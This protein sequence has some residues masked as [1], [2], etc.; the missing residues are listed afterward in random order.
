MT[1]RFFKM[2]KPVW[3]VIP[4]LMALLIT[5]LSVVRSDT[6][7]TESC[8]IADP[9]NLDFLVNAQGVPAIIL[10]TDFAADV[11]DVG[12]LAILNAMADSGEAD[13][14][15]VM[16]N[17]GDY[18]ALRAVDTINTYYGQPD[19]P[20][21]ATWA[22]AVSVTSKYTLALAVDFPNDLGVTPNAV[23]LYRQILAEQPDESVT[24]VSI[25]FLTNLH[26]LLASEPD[27]YSTLGGSALVAAKVR[28]LVVM[29]G[30][31]PDSASHP[32]GKEYNFAMDAAATNA[33]IPNWPTPIV[34]SGYELGVDIVTGA[35]LQEKTPSDNPMRTA[36]QL[37][38]GGVGRSS[39]DLTAAYF[40][41]RGP[42]DVW[43]LCGPGYNQVYPDGS[44][45]W[46]PST[47]HAHYY[48]R[49]AVSK[50]QIKALLDDLLTQP[51]K[52]E[53]VP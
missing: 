47:D 32:D 39:W 5:S 29:G 18:Y 17:S 34:F 30:Q 9:S 53:T 13:I 20:I 52:R 25:G 23:D 12:A 15:G 14:L 51:P 48:L 16:I 27:E 45:R 22:P 41:V 19:I 26:G 4:L 49:N 10:D 11:D 40:A 28:E 36:Y 6:P 8:S 7:K 33:V 35:T 38:N 37:Y 43:Q 1:M 31:Y 21:G 44:N 24:I 50:A 2:H 42:S 46:D 3:L